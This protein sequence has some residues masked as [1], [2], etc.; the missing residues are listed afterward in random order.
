[1][2]NSL[3]GFTRAELWGDKPLPEWMEEA[4]RVYGPLVRAYAIQLPNDR[5]IFLTKFERAWRLT[6]H[7][8]ANPPEVRDVDIWLTPEAMEAILFLEAM[9]HEGPRDPAN[10]FPALNAMLTVREQETPNVPD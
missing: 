9:L 10:P 8:P 1:M 4:E 2:E 7:N 3:R 6:L 5:T